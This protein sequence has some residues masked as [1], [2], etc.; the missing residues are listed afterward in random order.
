MNEKQFLAELKS[1]LHKLPESEREDIIMDFEEHFSIGKEGGKTEEEI[2]EALGSPQQIAKEMKAAY[3][4]EQVDHVSSAGNIFRAVW[5]T[6]GLGFF[7]LVFVL[8]P[9]IALLGIIFAGWIT[10]FAFITAL[11][12]VLIQALTSPGLFLWF[13]V[14]TSIALLGV[15]LILLIGMLYVT[16]V[17]SKGFVRYLHF[18]TRLVK[19]GMKDA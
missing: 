18:N 17:F 13:D 6:V 10:A 1:G 9:F 16:R 15:G 2:S 4:L 7:N 19:G 12:L 5:A 3:Y 8:G 14:F 11:P